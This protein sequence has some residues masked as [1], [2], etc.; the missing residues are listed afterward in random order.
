MVTLLWVCPNESNL[1]FRPYSTQANKSK[2]KGIAAP[3]QH[4]LGLQG[5]HLPILFLEIYPCPLAQGP[6]FLIGPGNMA[7]IPVPPSGV[8]RDQVSSATDL[9]CTTSYAA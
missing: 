1:V 2:L 6:S 7:G 8:N 9:L 5:A 3:I 4:P